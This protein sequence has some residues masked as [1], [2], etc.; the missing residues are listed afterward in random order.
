MKEK[1]TSAL[2]TKYSNLGFGDK[3]FDG[4]ADY[5]SKTVTEETQIETAIGGVE[6]LLKAFQSDTDRV[7]T[8]NATLKATIAKAEKAPAIGGEQAKIEPTAFDA[9]AFKKQLF[10]E[11][12]QTFNPIQEKI[13]GFEAAQAAAKR[14]ADIATAAKKYGIPE[15]IATKLSIAEDASLDDYMKGVK[16]DFANMGFEFAEPPVEGGG[17]SSSGSDIAN[18]IA[19]GTKEIVEQKK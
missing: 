9:D 10:E 12:K 13:Q 3:A 18:L 2:K 11:F 8:E 5:L 19:Q 6:S 17:A 15:P 7:R 4:V 16:Q 14:S 1:I